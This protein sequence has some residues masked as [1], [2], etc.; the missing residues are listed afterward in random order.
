MSRSRSSYHSHIFA[1]SFLMHLGIIVMISSTV[2]LSCCDFPGAYLFGR[3]LVPHVKTIPLRLGELKSFRELDHESV[4]EVFEDAGI[5]RILLRHEQNNVPDLMHEPELILGVLEPLVD[6]VLR[7][8]VEA[9]QPFSAVH[10]G[11]LVVFVL[12]HPFSGLKRLAD[13]HLDVT[14]KEFAEDMVVWAEREAALS[15]TVIS[16]LISPSGERRILGDTDKCFQISGCE[17][18]ERYAFHAVLVYGFHQLLD[19]PLAGSV[20]FKRGLN[21]PRAVFDLLLCFRY[22]ITSHPAR[23][24]PFYLLLRF[25]RGDPATDDRIVRLDGFAVHV[26]DY[27]LL[28]HHLSRARVYTDWVIGAHDTPSAKSI[29]ICFASSS[30]FAVH[31]PRP[32]LTV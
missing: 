16:L 11:V 9:F 3:A 6:V 17:M 29:A 22:Q 19:L 8:S 28:F 25:E 10:K 12:D 13:N 30:V 2:L 21:L 15:V 7:E 4:D 27:A 5:K 14:L 20:L 1:M 24:D 31:S 18:L 32:V 23:I 26:M